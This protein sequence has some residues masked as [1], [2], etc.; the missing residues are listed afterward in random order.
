MPPAGSPVVAI[1]YIDTVTALATQE[2]SQGPSY[3][4]WGNAEEGIDT[5]MPMANARFMF[6]FRYVTL[7]PSVTGMNAENARKNLC[8]NDRCVRFEANSP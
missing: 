5:L 6:P 1:P 4:F 3:F 2:G 7:A 8:S